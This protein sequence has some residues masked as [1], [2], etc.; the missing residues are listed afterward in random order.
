MSRGLRL[1]EYGRARDKQAVARAGCSPRDDHDHGD[2][3]DGDAVLFP[4]WWD[5]LDPGRHGEPVAQRPRL[6][7]TVTP[8]GWEYTREPAVEGYGDDE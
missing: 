7:F 4:S 6:F 2:L 5:D 1:T 8:G 3:Y